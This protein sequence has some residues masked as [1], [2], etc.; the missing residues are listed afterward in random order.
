MNNIW[1]LSLFSH[2][3]ERFQKREYFDEQEKP[4]KRISQMELFVIIILACMYVGGQMQGIYIGFIKGNKDFIYWFL[5][6]M[7]LF[8]FPTG[9]S[10][11]FFYSKFPIL[12]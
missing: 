11:L 5:C 2:L 4:K 8:G 6:A 3:K 12:M 1:K 10:M 7:A 9:I